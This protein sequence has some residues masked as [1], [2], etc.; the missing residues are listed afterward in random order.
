MNRLPA[1]LP[2]GRLRDA[3]TAAIR[4]DADAPATDAAADTVRS[5]PAA[6][7]ITTRARGRRR[8]GYRCSRCNHVEATYTAAERHADTHGAAR[9]DAVLDAA[10]ADLEAV[11]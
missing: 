11:T 1:T 5:A 3:V 6:R 7:P 9:I 10:E 4:A 2:A 8:L